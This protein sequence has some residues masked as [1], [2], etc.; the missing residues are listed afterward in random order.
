M[1]TLFFLRVTVWMLPVVCFQGWT[2]T[3]ILAGF[4]KKK[5]YL[6]REIQ[7]STARFQHAGQLWSRTSST[8]VGVWGQG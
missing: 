1:A 5:K 2:V 7:L 6:E 3:F 4:P 8:K